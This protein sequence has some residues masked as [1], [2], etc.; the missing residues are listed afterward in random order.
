[1]KSLPFALLL[2]LIAGCGKNDA[3]NPEPEP[4]RQL[5]RAN[6]QLTPIEGYSR[7]A[8]AQPVSY[9]SV[10]VVPIVDVSV[11]AKPDTGSE[12]QDEYISLEEARKN[13]WIEIHEIPGSAEVNSLE[14]RNDGPKPI[15]LLAGE[16]LLGGQ[17]DRIVAKDTVVPP[18]K[19]VEVPVFCVEPGRWEGED[20]SFG[21]GGGMVPQSIREET[22]LSQDQGK[23]WEGVGRYNDN[24]K[25]SMGLDFGGSSVR[26]SYKSKE[27]EAKIDKGLSELVKALDGVKNIVGYVYVSNGEVQSAELFGNARLFSAARD[28]LLRG[29]LAD[30]AVTEAKQDAKVAMADCVGFFKDVMAGERRQT[31]LRAGNADW[32]IHSSDVSGM[33]ATMPAA[34]ASMPGDANNEFMHGS[35][36]KKKD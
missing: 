33:E 7:Y 12:K 32:Q 30:G 23:V 31:A 34:R 5:P 8:L 17:Q 19:T 28:S 10:S 2:I 27:V 18:G 29:L 20:K 21:S 36:S 16:L 3:P 24:A 13:A 25:A 35:Y 9:G 6:T 1:M 15:L 26:G 11:D 4:G 14:V 22:T